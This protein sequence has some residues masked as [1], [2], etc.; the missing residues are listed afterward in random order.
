MDRGPAD[1]RGHSAALRRRLLGCDAEIAAI[2]RSLDDAR[3]GRGARI[4]AVIGDC[5][6]GKSAL[7]EHAAARADDMRVL[8]CVGAPAEAALAFA[9]L[10]QM[11]RPLLSLISRLPGSQAAAIRSVFGVSEDRV[12][13]RFVIS[14]AVLG[15][16]SEAADEMPH[17]EMRAMTAQ[18]SI[19]SNILGG[20]PGE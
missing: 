7:L 5:G 13:D 6:F 16:L 14:V 3:A 2:E 8:R 12:E 19:L 11:V 18:R 9:G 17:A 10:L 20:R 15:L 4:M 1:D